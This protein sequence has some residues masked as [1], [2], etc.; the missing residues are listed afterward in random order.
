ME[1]KWEREAE[2]KFAENMKV[3]EAVKEGKEALERYKAAWEVRFGCLDRMSEERKEKIKYLKGWNELGG[4]K[5][6]DKR[7]D[8]VLEK[9]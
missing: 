4:K 1:T 7:D 2:A 9:D 6:Y 5:G 3:V 8:S